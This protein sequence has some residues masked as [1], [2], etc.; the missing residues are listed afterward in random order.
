MAMATAASAAADGD[1]GGADPLV[2]T[3]APASAAT[4]STFA[5]ALAPSS[6]IPWY[7]S[8]GV[9]A[10][11][12]LPAVFMP[13]GETGAP[14]VHV[15]LADAAVRHAAFDSSVHDAPSRESDVKLIADD[16]SDERG[17]DIAAVIFDLDG[18]LLDTEP[19]STEAINLALADI[20]RDLGGGGGTQAPMIVEWEL[21]SELIGLRD[22]E[23]AA[24]VL[25]HFGLA[26]LGVAPHLLVDA[27]H[28]HLHTLLPHAA[29]LPGAHALVQA[30]VARRI[31]IAL[32]TSSTAAAVAVKRG[33]AAHAAMFAAFGAAI[34]CGD[35]A[36]VTRGKPAP[37]IFL[38]AAAVLG[39]RPAQCL[40]VED[41]PAGACERGL[42]LPRASHVPDL[43][44][45][46]D[47]LA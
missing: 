47:A 41:S 8:K 10:A 31:P 15:D 37:D 3:P 13:T 35:D 26:A 29:A 20:Q 40:V 30:L 44:L 46:C 27:W 39:V 22:A 4:A 17:G 2:A 36:R 14:S 32:A 1:A 23:W 7:S 9:A 24:K 11:D 5:P 6:A 18:T 45:A 33:N 25:D 16:D 38:C 12:P 43:H 42:F 19:L 34:V 21:K 28:R